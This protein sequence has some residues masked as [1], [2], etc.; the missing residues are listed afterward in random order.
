MTKVGL[1]EFVKMLDIEERWDRVLSLGQQQRLAFARLLLHKPAWVFMDE[2]TGA[3]DEDN[4]ARVMNLVNSE[5]PQSTVLSIGHRPSLAEFHTRTLHLVPTPSGA[6]LRRH[7]H[8]AAQKAWLLQTFQ[9]WWQT[10]S[11]KAS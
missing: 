7:K 8:P 10:R 1:E 6:R 11:D 2:A 9:G 3:L 4:Q 5:L